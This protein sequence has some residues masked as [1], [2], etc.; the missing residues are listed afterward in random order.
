M[1]DSF[2]FPWTVTHQV[3]LSVTFPRQ[4][5]W[6]R[7]PFPSPGDPPDSEIKPTSSALQVDSLPLSRLRLG[8]CNITPEAQ[9]EKDK[10]WIST[11]ILYHD[12]FVQI[13]CCTDNDIKHFKVMQ[14]L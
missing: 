5:Y 1:S 2:A 12:A 13:S 9:E 8:M 11:S 7:L 10:I 4:E 3:P 14:Q 6:S